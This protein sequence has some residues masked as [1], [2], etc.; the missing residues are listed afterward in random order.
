MVGSPQIT[1]IT[2]NVSD[3]Y[4]YIILER[5]LVCLYEQIWPTSRPPS[6][7]VSKS[8]LLAYPLPPLWSHDENCIHSNHEE[9]GAPV[10]ASVGEE[11]DVYTGCLRKRCALL[12]RLQDW[13]GGW[14]FNVTENHQVDHMNIFMLQRVMCV[15]RITISSES[16]VLK[17]DSYG[18][19]SFLY[20][21]NC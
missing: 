5:S 1:L 21:Q 11:Y 13:T 7:L 12:A 6:P 19:S 14:F 20:D 15:L 4:T 3:I 17:T 18:K 16:K 8:D 10:A 9:G 2:I